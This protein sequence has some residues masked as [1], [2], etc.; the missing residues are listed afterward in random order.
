MNKPSNWLYLQHLWLCDL[1]D[2]EQLPVPDMFLAHVLITAVFLF[3]KGY[4][5]FRVISGEDCRWWF[6]TL[7]AVSFTPL[8]CKGFGCEVHDTSALKA[9]SQEQHSAQGRVW[10]GR[11][12]CEMRRLTEGRP[13][14]IP[15]T[16]LKP[17]WDE[18]YF[19][20]C[21]EQK[22]TLVCCFRFCAVA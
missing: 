9:R 10:E 4:I 5:W 3:S 21:Q 8:S 16:L 7:D 2:G 1:R 19:L 14:P 15:S 22:L 20:I 6:T 18:S 11:E 17:D 13:G 12:K